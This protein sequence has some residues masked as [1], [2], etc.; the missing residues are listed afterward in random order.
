[1]TSLLSPLAT[2]TPA[3]N[4]RSQITAEKLTYATSSLN[5]TAISIFDLYNAHNCIYKPLSGQP[6]KSAS[7]PVVLLAKCNRPLQGEINTIIKLNKFSNKLTDITQCFKPLSN[8]KLLIEKI[9]SSIKEN[10]GFFEENILKTSYKFTDET[11]QIFDSIMAEIYFYSL[12]NKLYDY[13]IS[14]HLIYNINSRIYK[15]EELLGNLPNRNKKLEESF[16]SMFKLS[17]IQP[18]QLFAEVNSN[19]TPYLLKLKDFINKLLNDIDRNIYGDKLTIDDGF[20]ILSI[21]ISQLLYTLQCFELIGFSHNDLHFENILVFCDNDIVYTK[22]FKHKSN[23]NNVRYFEY[24]YIDDNGNYHKMKLPDIGLDIKIYDY[25]ISCK[26]I[27]YKHKHKP[28][29]NTNKSSENKSPE[30]NSKFRTPV[31]AISS[32]KNRTNKRGNR[33][34]EN[35]YQDIDKF[36]NLEGKSDFELLSSKLHSYST[37]RSYF[38]SQMDNTFTHDKFKVINNIMNMIN[39]YSNSSNVSSLLERFS[40]VFYQDYEGINTFEEIFATRFARNGPNSDS[41]Y[42]RTHK[43]INL[44]VDSPIFKLL[45]YTPTPIS[46]NNI[47]YVEIPSHE[48][49][50]TNVAY[51]IPIIIISAKNKSSD[52]GN[53]QYY[54]LDVKKILKPTAEIFSILQTHIPQPILSTSNKTSSS[55]T[56]ILNFNNNRNNRNNRSNKNNRSKIARSFSV[57]NIVKYAYDIFTPIYDNI[58]IS[59][60]GSIKSSLNPHNNLLLSGGEG[61]LI[62]TP[63]KKE[64][65]RERNSSI[66]PIKSKFTKKNSQIP[67][68]P[69]GTATEPVGTATEPVGTT[70]NNNTP[71][72]AHENGARSSNSPYY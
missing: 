10:Y 2:T 15:S 34:S 51:S 67:T 39:A 55:F 22:Y 12:M 32:G 11:S 9:I 58:E 23:P 64:G 33:S 27:K 62:I 57:S 5:P 44:D 6:E 37:N 50:N 17:T 53:N 60:I 30:N 49:Y 40:H 26:S 8:N 20:I 4:L 59:G 69:L 63:T 41:K 19:T 54:K 56:K 65:K 13:N 36:F 46:F 45:A 43:N 66:T 31:K 28:P 25:D 71:D 7:K 47:N 52:N 3:R 70:N 38:L 68:E 21:I 24:E 35:F 14:Q 16:K 29:T 42:N 72:N 18:T 61:G 48:E 1:M